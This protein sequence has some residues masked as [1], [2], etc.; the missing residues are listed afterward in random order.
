MRVLKLVYLLVGLAL[1]GLLL[2]QAD[3]GEVGTRLWQVGW[4]LLP[5]CLIHFVAFML[6]V[7]AWQF[8]LLAVRPGDARWTYRLWKLRMA[9]EAYNNITP[10]ASVGGE[11]LKAILL[12][13]HYGIGFRDGIASLVLART[14]ILMGLLPFLAIGFVFVLQSPKLP[15]TY[16][17]VAGAGLAAFTLAVLL[18]FAVQRYKVSSLAGTFL[19][20]GRLRHRIESVLHQIREMEGRLIHFYTRHP[21]RVIGAVL[22]AF[23]NWAIGVIEIWVIMYAVGV[24]ISWSDALIIEAMTQLVR[25]GVF[26]IPAGIGVQEGTFVLLCAALTGNPSVGLAVAGVRRVKELIWIVWGVALGW[27]YSMRPGDAARAAKRIERSKDM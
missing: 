8:S 20:R 15:Q 23:L 27:T 19:A 12:K 13:S 2:W 4:W 17:V 25:A 24:P 14:V 3:L 26:F 1:L 6:D 11:P 16:Q 9:G 21:R 18:F 7:W 5:I 10:L 22:F